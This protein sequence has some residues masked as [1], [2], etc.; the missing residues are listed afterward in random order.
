MH[1]Q[2]HGVMP[3]L[4]DGP[5]KRKLESRRLR[6]YVIVLVLLPIHRKSGKGTPPLG[7]PTVNSRYSL[8]NPWTRPPGLSNTGLINGSPY[9]TIRQVRTQR[10]TRYT[11]HYRKKTGLRLP[12]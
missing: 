10:L 7:G 6:M 4:P 9:T 3:L 11:G 12:A 5:P 8:S 2:R 1:G